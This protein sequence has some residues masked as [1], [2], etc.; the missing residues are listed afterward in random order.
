MDANAA[1]TTNNRKYCNGMQTPSVLPSVEHRKK[2]WSELKESVT[3]LRKQLSRLAT[4][5]PMNIEFRRLT[6]GRTRIYFLSMPPN[7]WETTLLCTDIPPIVGSSSSST[8]N[9]GTSECGAH[10]T[11]NPATSQRQRLISTHFD[12]ISRFMS[13]FILSFHVSFLCFVLRPS[14]SQIAVAT[15]VGT[16]GAEFI[17]KQYVRAGLSI[18]VG[19]KAFVDVG[20]HIVRDT[21]TKRSHHISCIEYTVPVLRYRI[22]RKYSIL[23]LMVSFVVVRSCLCAYIRGLGVSCHMC[24]CVFVPKSINFDLI[25]SS[26]KRKNLICFSR[27]HCIHRN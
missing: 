16:I 12:P 1:S 18:V 10:D 11:S 20:H 21:Q 15:V 25:F 24:S 7:G 22:Q 26:V 9:S 4:M 2:S 8:S 3:D 6:D 19:T 27:I 13:H 17:D 14:I 23:T 5:I